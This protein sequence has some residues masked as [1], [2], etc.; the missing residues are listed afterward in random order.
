MLI[1]RPDKYPQD[2]DVAELWTDL[3]DFLRVPLKVRASAG[4]VDALGSE[5]ELDD[6]GSDERGRGRRATER[7]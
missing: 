1:W 3:V 7:P 2:A 4:W 6:L 5:G